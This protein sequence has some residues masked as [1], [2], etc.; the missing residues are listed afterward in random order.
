MLS[1]Q[2]ISSFFLQR[3]FFP[4]QKIEFQSEEASSA[5][6]SK[7]FHAISNSF[8]FQSNLE[9]KLLSRDSIF[10]SKKNTFHFIA[11]N[12][13][14]L[15]KRGFHFISPEKNQPV[16]CSLRQR[17]ENLNLFFLAE[18]CFPGRLRIFHLPEIW[19]SNLFDSFR[20]HH[21]HGGHP[22]DFPEY[23]MRVKIWKK[24]IGPKGREAFVCLSYS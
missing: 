11:Q 24:K 9:K 21:H 16:F 13:F 15:S 2:N 6:A 19:L 14:F 12:L 1:T 5:D 20:H 8:V 3:I 10:I 22:I 7:P 4:P 23:K 17:R 18:V